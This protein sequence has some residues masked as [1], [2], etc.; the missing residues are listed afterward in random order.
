MSDD[1][2]QQ[3]CERTAERFEGFGHLMPFRVQEVLLVASLYDA[4]TLEEG[5]R[6]T[7]LL[8]KEYRELN[9]SFAPRITKA[10]SGRE[11]LSLIAT[12]RFDLVLTMSRLGDL[13]AT[14]LARQ[15]KRT[16]PDL[17]VYAL[18]LNPRELQFLR[19]QNT[20][21]VLDRVF[22][23]TGD[24]RL[25][26]AA[27]KSWEDQRN[28]PHDT[29]YG[30]VRVILLIEDSER[31]Y[32]IYLPL[33]Y[34]EIV[35]QTQ[36]LMDEGINLSH[37]LL[38]MRARP[39]ILLATSFEEAWHWFDRY[40]AS[41]LGVIAD[42]RFPW[43]GE[44]N[45]SAGVAFI[46]QIKAVDPNLPAV[47]QSTD[48]D[49]KPQA[50][51]VGA[52]FI[53][54]DSPQ[55]MQ[56]LRRFMAE[57]FGFGDFVF[58]LLD[59]REVGRAR[60]LREMVRVLESVPDE[61]LLHHAGQDHFSTWLRA[62][63]EF[64]LAALIR[65]RKIHE[66]DSATRLRAWLIDSMQR[67]RMESQRGVVV[68]F[69]RHR[70]EAS[71]G[72][73][74][75]GSGSL[76]GKA[77]GLAFIDSV[78]NRLDLGER[79]PGVTIA[80]PPTAV[81][82]TDV[83]DKFLDKNRLR[84]KVLCDHLDDG[85]IVDLFLAQP[86]PAEALADLRAFLEAVRYPLAV[87]SSSL[88]EDSR[89]QPFAGV[90]STYMLPNNHGDLQVRLDQLGAAIKL[91]YASVFQASAREYLEAS[92]NRVEEEKMAV[93][94]QQ[95]V[96]RQHERYFYPDFAGVAH[97]TDY[98]PPPG[99]TPAEGVVCA[100][101]GLGRMV[102]DGGNVMRFNPRR[103]GKLQQFGTIND[104]LKGSQREFLA[105]DL[106]QASATPQ[107]SET[108][109]LVKLDLADA[110]RHGTLT[111][112]GS[113]YSPEN[114]IIY[115]GIDRSGPRLVSFANVL[116]NRLFPLAEIMAFLLELGRHC[117]SGPVEIEWA[118]ALSDDP[119]ARSRFGFLQIRPLTLLGNGISLA[120]EDLEDPAALIT[121]EV[122]LGNGD[123]PDLYDVVYVP[124]GRF[125]RAA[126][127]AVAAEIAALNAKLRA[128]GRPYL[129][130]GPG[131]WGSS[132]R[133]LGIP[134]RWEQISQAQ[135]IVETDLPDF[136]VT[137]SEGTH[138]FQNLTSFQVGYLTVNEGRS[139]TVCR[140][141]LLEALPEVAQGAYVRHVRLE[142]PLVV[143]I[144]GR[145]RRAKVR[146][147]APNRKI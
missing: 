91:V 79:F 136:K 46:R 10:T 71:S 17:P 32:S 57:N 55:L 44:L 127:A 40:Q 128:E 3:L 4:F 129:L 141:E 99:M 123:Y 134:V 126:T 137:P 115:D 114:G 33:L 144:D 132:D 16:R 133:W 30:D 90:Y 42:G 86:L 74:R 11:A 104:W 25:L 28:L 58:R 102:A 145:S 108:F 109:N 65:P 2:W 113:T 70:F 14:E 143:V 117:L 121:T 146:I 84:E 6:L 5:G 93:V 73:S 45:E 97:S 31:F 78:L 54:K 98:Y 89:F 76:G 23:W 39:K 18:V 105:V 24:V 138:F 43:R 142:Q 34:T 111:A 12:R 52:G 77:R 60:N 56:D 116:K 48:H 8:L 92:G 75:I 27:I 64:A 69:A 130:L 49:L 9:L 119:D 47:M 135:V 36:A 110:E 85:Q 7:E 59:G 72:F 103:P 37:R 51:A 22:L 81:L 19:A 62:R 88:L 107:A 61:S 41:L 118:A 96:G 15:V 82:A 53:P 124:P 122:A 100:A 21:R 50:A 87:R 140:W 29:R 94:L 101:L 13:Q 139:H 68:E 106:L 83:F 147:Q 35:R 20:E 112:V 125:E 95:I 1:F 131:R 67:F 38:R 26:L 63:T 66:F 80:V 120:L